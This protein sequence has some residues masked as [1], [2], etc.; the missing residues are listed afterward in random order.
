[1]LQKTG[2]IPTKNYPDASEFLNLNFALF[3]YRFLGSDDQDTYFTNKDRSRVVY[4]ILSTA[5]YGKRK[6]AE[7]G[8]ERLLEE[9]VLTAAFPMHDV[10]I[11][12]GFVYIDT[13]ANAISLPDG[14]IE[15]PI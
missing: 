2:M 7:I 10:R 5:S 8:I 11:T 3:F 4:E 15:N 1:M 9:D 13:N 14:F 12:L 6:R